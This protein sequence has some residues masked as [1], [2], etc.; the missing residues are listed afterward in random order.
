MYA[1]APKGNHAALYISQDAGGIWIMDQWKD[2]VKKPTRSK[3]Y[4]RKLAQNTDG[5][6]SDASNNAVAYRVVE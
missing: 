4:V 6:Y 5:S 3:R 2:D 1:K